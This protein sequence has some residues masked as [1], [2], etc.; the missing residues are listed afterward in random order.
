MAFSKLDPFCTLSLS[1]PKM[2]FETLRKE[3]LELKQDTIVY[4]VKKALLPLSLVSLL[5]MIFVKRSGKID[6]KKVRSKKAIN[7]EEEVVY[8]L[9][10]LVSVLVNVILFELS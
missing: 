5:W 7:D 2:D 10:N 6:K 3:I 1:S 9:Q 4:Y 8:N